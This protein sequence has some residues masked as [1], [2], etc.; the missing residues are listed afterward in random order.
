MMALPF[1]F[2][3][4]VINFPAGLLVYWIT[5]NLWTVGQG[6]VVRRLAPPARAG[7]LRVP[8]GC[9]RPPGARRRRPSEKTTT[10]PRRERRVAPSDADGRE[11]APRR[12]HRGAAPPPPPRKK[13]KR[14]GRRR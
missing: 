3:A 5:T 8:R 1:V 2:V 9:P 10:G 6:L 4:F 14:S 11:A 7:R 13:K 12:P